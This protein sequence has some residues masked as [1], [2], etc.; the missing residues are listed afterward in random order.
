MAADATSALAPSV[1]DTPPS[2]GE[3]ASP[4]IA[5]AIPQ[6]SSEAGAGADA[7]LEYDGSDDAFASNAARA[8]AT[9][10]MQIQAAAAAPEDD[11]NNSTARYVI[12]IIGVA[13]ALIAAAIALRWW[14]RRGERSS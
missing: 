5:A 10:A 8:V 9:A 13:A 2:A 11:G 3:V 7:S 4:E 12:E 1:G 14:R 6:P